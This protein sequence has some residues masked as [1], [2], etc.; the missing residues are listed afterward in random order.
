VG[1]RRVKIEDCRVEQFDDD[2]VLDGTTDVSLRRCVLLDVAS[3]CGAPAHQL[4]IYGCGGTVRIVSCVF[5]QNTATTGASHHHVFAPHGNHRVAVTECVVARSQGTAL[6]LDATRNVVSG[7]ILIGNRLH[8]AVGGS[9]ATVRGNLVLGGRD[10]SAA[11]EPARRTGAPP[12]AIWATADDLNI[13][14]NVIAHRR[15]ARA[16]A[17]VLARARREPETFRPTGRIR[18]ADNVLYGCGGGIEICGEA[19][20]RGVE[21]LRNDLQRLAAGQRV[22]S[23]KDSSTSLVARDNRYGMLDPADDAAIRFRVGSERLSF[24]EWARRTGDTSVVLRTGGAAHAARLPRRFIADAR[25]QSGAS[26]WTHLSPA[27]VVPR[28][29]LAFDLPRPTETLP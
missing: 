13:E 5:D 28:F 27:A 7:N 20:W 8:I 1:V 14:R 4:A 24:R 17:I 25:A 22:F 21:L 6:L 15:R 16:A 18:V 19:A 3:S 23:V 9:G 2:V 12:H 29:F 11:E 10:R 26:W